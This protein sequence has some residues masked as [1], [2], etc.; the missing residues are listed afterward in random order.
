MYIANNYDNFNCLVEQ[1]ESHSFGLRMLFPVWA[2][3]GL[4][5]LFPVL[6]SFPLFVTKKELTTLTPVSYTH[7]MCIRD[8]NMEGKAEEWK[9]SCLTIL[10]LKYFLSSWHFLFGWQW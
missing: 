7:L 5:F 1:L 2:L 10:G 9:K 4:K 6:V 8:R 3:T